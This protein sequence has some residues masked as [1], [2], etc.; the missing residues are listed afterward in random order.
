MQDC[1][2]IRD[3]HRFRPVVGDVEGGDAEGLVEAPDLESHFSRRFASSRSRSA[4]ETPDL[5][6]RP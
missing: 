6:L 4:F 5:N 3:D 2:A 1:D